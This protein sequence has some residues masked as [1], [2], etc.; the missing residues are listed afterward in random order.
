ML[1]YSV[2]TL[3]IFHL[4]RKNGDTLVTSTDEDLRFFLLHADNNKDVSRK[5]SLI[6]PE[7]SRLMQG[8]CLWRDTDKDVS[9]EN[10]KVKRFMET[11]RNSK[12]PKLERY[13]LSLFS[14]TLWPWLG[15]AIIWDRS[16]IDSLPAA[17]FE[18]KGYN[19][20][21]KKGFSPKDSGSL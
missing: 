9:I 11:M 20:P 8:C 17:K 16:E 6:K 19:L 7:D 12:H 14:L 3:L 15:D 18:K 5:N 4:G 21:P 10:S 13:S 2:A 1:V